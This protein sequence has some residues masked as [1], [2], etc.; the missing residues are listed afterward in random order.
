VFENL[1]YGNALYVLYEDW[2]E[3]SR[4][5]RLDLLRDHDASFDRIIHTEDWED[6]FHHLVAGEDQGA[7]PPPPIAMIGSFLSTLTTGRPL[8]RLN[9][10]RQSRLDLPWDASAH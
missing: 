3:V 8:E 5:S 2:D 6:R 9:P 1:K 7:P 4:R 10:F